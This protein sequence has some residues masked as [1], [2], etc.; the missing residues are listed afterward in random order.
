[1]AALW[2]AV[3]L[4]VRV[5]VVALVWVQAGVR[6]VPWAFRLV[7]AAAVLTVL[8]VFTV[9]TKQL[10]SGGRKGGFVQH[11][12][13]DT[14]KWIFLRASSCVT[15]HRS[16]THTCT[17]LVYTGFSP[18][19]AFLFIIIIPF[20]LTAAAA[21]AAW[22]VAG[23]SGS[24]LLRVWSGARARLWNTTNGRFVLWPKVQFICWMLSLPSETYEALM[25]FFITNHFA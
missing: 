12:K 6:L 21:T 15:V 14:T 1:M 8:L 3:L 19:L 4:R 18:F 20:P 7:I 13:N 16:H 17:H 24:L 9:V 5:I 22:G 11:Y 2:A 25:L 23:R 10:L